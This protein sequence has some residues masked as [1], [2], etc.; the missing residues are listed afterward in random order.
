MQGA[1]G[2]FWLH[3][4]CN[5]HFVT[6]LKKGTFF[7]RR[8]LANTKQSMSFVSDARRGRNEVEEKVFF[9]EML[10]SKDLHEPKNTL[11]LDKKHFA[12]NNLKEIYVP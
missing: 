1:L 3:S 6:I 11:G 2:Y 5:K 10:S 12:V 8:S 7:G 9:Q 4:P